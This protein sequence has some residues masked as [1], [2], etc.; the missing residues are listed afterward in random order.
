MSGI[1]A[2]SSARSI[3]EA[4]RRAEMM[5]L[6]AEGLTLAQI[7][8]QMGI[9]ADAVQGVIDRALRSMVKAPADELRALEL[10]RCDELMTEAMA[11]VRA[12]MQT[13]RSGDPVQDPESCAVVV[14]VVADAAPKLA[15][16]NTVLRVMERRARLLGLDMPTKTA[17]TDPSGTVSA[18]VVTFYMPVNGRDVIDA[19]PQPGDMNP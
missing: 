16:I 17:L 3:R 14:E 1:Q 10:A 5:R 19:T 4:Q 18:G 6:R 11:I 2:R 13:V 12:P 8:E 7:G 15:A 9:T